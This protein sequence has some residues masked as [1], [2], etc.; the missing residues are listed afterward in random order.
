MA[1]ITPASKLLNLEEFAQLPPTDCPRELVRG[2]IVLMNPPYPWHGFVCA[3]VVRIF[4][5]F[6]DQHKLGTACCNDAGVVTERDPDTL[7]GADFSFYSFVRLPKEG[8]PK[9]GYALVAPDLVVEV[10]SPDQAWK[11]L[12]AKVAEYL[13]AGVAVVLVVDPQRQTVTIYR[14]DQPEETLAQEDDLSLPDVLPGF[15][16]KVAALF[17]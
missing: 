7:R 3:R 11:N 6:I 16:V 17:E 8:L 2:R 5:G 10:R 15:S 9:K 12:L 14:P 13:N 4:G 1:V